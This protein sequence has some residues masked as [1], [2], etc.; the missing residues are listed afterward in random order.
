MVAQGMVTVLETVLVT[1]RVAAM[2]TVMCLVTWVVVMET[3]L[4]LIIVVTLTVLVVP[5]TM[6]TMTTKAT[7]TRRHPISRLDPVSACP[8]FISDG[9][10]AT[11]TARRTIGG[12]ETGELCPA[13][14]VAVAA[15]MA[16]GG[17]VPVHFPRPLVGLWQ[18]ATRTRTRA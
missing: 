12:E 10:T 9:V 4:S 2:A 13:A 7:S 8:E 11:M 3:V 17:K 15:T 1:A 14:A 6:V 18:R 16:V 5:R